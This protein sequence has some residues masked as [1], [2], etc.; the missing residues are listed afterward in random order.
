MATSIKNFMDEDGRIKQWP[1]KHALKAEV[2]SYLA[3]KFETGVDYTEH[4]VNAIVSRW[5][6]FGDYFLLRRALVEAGLLCRPPD[7]SRYWKPIREESND[8]P[9]A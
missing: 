6:T 9:Q 1:A 4:D 5:H 8:P 3:E 2:L 7:G